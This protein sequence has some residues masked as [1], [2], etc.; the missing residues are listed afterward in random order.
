MNPHQKNAR[1]KSFVPNS[2]ALVKKLIHSSG[3]NVPY[4]KENM[5]K[6]GNG[7]SGPKDQK[8]NFDVLCKVVLILPAKYDVI[9]EVEDTKEHFDAETMANHK[10]VVYYVMNNGCAEEQQA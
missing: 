2:K 8:P 7:A 1:T 3:Q 10:L 4:H 6:E 5:P 9:S